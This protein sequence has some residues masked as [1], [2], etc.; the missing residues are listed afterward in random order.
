MF[1]VLLT[2]A[3]PETREAVL[4][5]GQTVTLDFIKAAQREVGIDNLDTLIEYGVVKAA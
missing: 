2:V 4:T 5:A 3:H 1:T